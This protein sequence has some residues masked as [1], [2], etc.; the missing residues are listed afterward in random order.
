MTKKLVLVQDLLYFVDIFKQ[1]VYLNVN[2]NP[3]YSTIIGSLISFLLVPIVIFLFFQSPMFLKIN[4][5]IIDQTKRNSFSAGLG[6][7]NNNFQL[8][9]GVTDNL[10]R[11]FHIDPTIFKINLVYLSYVTD[12]TNKTNVEIN[13]DIRNLTLCNESN[14]TASRQLYEDLNLNNYLCPDNNTYYLEGYYGEPNI[15]G[16]SIA[17][18]ICNNDTD[19]VMCQPIDK[20]TEFFSN[21]WIGFTIGFTQY[22]YDVLNISSP[23][24]GS[25]EV[26]SLQITVDQSK[27]RGIFLKNLQ[28]LNDEGWIMADEKISNSFMLDTTIDYLGSA[29]FENQNSWL[30]N[31]I[32]FSFFASKNFQNVS[33]RYQKIQELLGSI[34]GTL[35]FLIM[36]GYFLTSIQIKLNVVKL[37]MN[38]LYSFPAKADSYMKKT[39]KSPF[40][41]KIDFHANDAIECQLK[42]DFA[43][44]I[45]LPTYKGSLNALKHIC[46]VEGKN[47]TSEKKS[48]I[49]E[50]EIEKWKKKENININIFQ[51]LQMKFRCFAQNS[52]LSLF[53]KAEEMVK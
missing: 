29:N 35:S 13:Y 32:S 42:N 31:I 21:E 41:C 1:P 20:I 52:I 10:N 50:K 14:Q 22:N 26:S 2:N 40:F 47:V 6:L 9:I 38:E 12:Q 27:N 5:A 45:E 51:Y 36:I 33:R 8:Y 46:D 18:S 44:S 24:Q 37:L 30:N 3:K 7:E 43:P 4:P 17:L 34:N 19:G 39:E 23:I 15:F 49:T 16:F 11:G 53:N 25:I 28:F 48:Q